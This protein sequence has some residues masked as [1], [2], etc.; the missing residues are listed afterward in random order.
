V[1][2]GCRSFS[3]L[4]FTN[5]P[6]PSPLEHTH[7]QDAKRVESSLAAGASPDTADDEVGLYK[8]RSAEP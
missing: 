6:S 8:L 1:C 4:F 7:Q 5:T 2:V 3:N